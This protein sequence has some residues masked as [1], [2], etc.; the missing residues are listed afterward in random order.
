MEEQRKRK[1]KPK[2]DYFKVNLLRYWSWTLY[3][4]RLLLY[5]CSGRRTLR[6]TRQIQIRWWLTI[7]SEEEKKREIFTLIVTEWEKKIF[8]QIL[9]YGKWPSWGAVKN[10]LLMDE[11]PISLP[12]PRT[13]YFS[14]SRVI[15]YIVWPSKI[16]FQQLGTLFKK[17]IL[18]KPLNSRDLVHLLLFRYFSIYGRFRVMNVQFQENDFCSKEYVLMVFLYGFLKSLWKAFRIWFKVLVNS[19]LRIFH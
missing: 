8:Q 9:V 16:N 4:A 10:S 5:C 6:Y 12:T 3:L 11:R 18:P 1:I 2:I 14:E 15:S 13:P 17:S 19:D 7:H